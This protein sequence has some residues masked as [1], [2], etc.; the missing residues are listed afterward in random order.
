LQGHIWLPQR[1]NAANFCRLEVVGVR[2]YPL[3]THSRGVGDGFVTQQRTVGRQKHP[4]VGVQSSF[5]LL[6]LGFAA[7]QVG[8]RG[9]VA[10]FATLQMGKWMANGPFA[11]VQMDKF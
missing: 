3:P 11:T 9:A 2:L 5:V 7:M 10:P 1:L 8:K 4:S 6:V